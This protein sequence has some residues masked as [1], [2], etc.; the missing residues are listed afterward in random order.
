MPSDQDQQSRLDD[1]QV[2]AISA[3]VRTLFAQVRTPDNSPT[4]LFDV[5]GSLQPE[6]QLLKELVLL[7]QEVAMLRVRLGE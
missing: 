7:R 5:M 3:V 1:A 6:P 4:R 2:E